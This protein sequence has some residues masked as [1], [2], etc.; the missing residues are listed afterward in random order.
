MTGYILRPDLRTCKALGC[1]PTLLFANRFDIRQVSLQMSSINSRYTAILKGLHNAIALDYHYKKGLIFWSDMALDVIKQ[2]CI[3]G[4]KKED[5][6]KWGLESPGGI[7]LDWIHDLIFWTDSGTRRVEVATLDGTKRAIL[8]ANDLDKPRAIVVHP[9]HALVFWT[10]WGPRPKIERIEMD[11]SNR[12]SIITESVFWPNGLTLDFTSDRIYWADAK[13]NVIETALFDGNDRRKVISKGLPHPFALTIFEDAIYWT[14]WHTK[15]ISTANK[16]TGAGMRTIHANLHFPMDIH[17]FHAQRQPQYK[18]H[19]GENNGGCE[20]LCLP[21]KN[22]YTCLCQMGQKLNSDKKTCQQPEKLLV[23]VR[24]KDLRIKQLDSDAAHHHEIV[25]P[26]D[27]IKSAVAIAWESKTDMI[28]WTDVEKDTINRAHWNGSNHQVVI[29]TNAISP[30]GLAYDWYTDKL[31]WTDDGTAKIEV[32]NSDGTL[33]GILIWED[34]DRPRD[35]VVD[36][37]NGYMYWSDWGEKPKIERAAMDGTMRSVLI[38]HNLTWPN[39]LAIDYDTNRLYWSDGGTSSIEYSNLDGS[40][41][42]ILLEGSSLPHPF[43]LDV[44]G[45]NVYWTDWETLKIERA[46]KFTGQNRKVISTGITDLMDVRAFHRNRKY[47]TTSCHINNGGCSDLCLLKPKGHSCAC[48]IGIALMKDGRTCPKGPINS[49]IIAHRVDIRQ[50]SL[51]VPYIV[52][53]V[54][55]FPPLKNVM[56]VDVDRKTGEVYWTDTSADVIQKN[57][58][59]GKTPRTII[60]HELQMADGITIDSTGRKMY[61]TDGGR[62]SIEVAELDGTNRKVLIWSDLDTPRAIALHY[63]HGLMF[64]SD[65]GTKAKIEVAQMDGSHR[66]ALITTN[67]AWPNGLAIDRPSERLYWND[68]KLKTIE[69]S[70]LNGNDRR[71]IIVGVPHP[72]GLVVVGNH[73]YWTDWQTQGLHRAEKHNGSDRTVIREKLEGLMDI[74][75]VQSD[76]IAENACGNN[77]GGCSHLCLRNSKGYSC[78]CPTG[79]NFKSGSDK[80]CEHQPLNYLMFT[81]RS[82][83]VRISLDTKELFEVTLPIKKLQ[84]VID[85]DFHWKKQ[86]IFISDIDLGGIE[87]INMKNFSDRRDI[88]SDNSTIPN[89]IAVD[90]ISNLIYWTDGAKKVIELCKIDGTMRHVV[91]KDNLQEPRSIATFPRRGYLFWTDWGAQPKIERSFLDGSGRRVLFNQDL[92]FP[93]GI[94]IDY[95]GKRLYW[96]DA[97][98]DR[99]ETSDLHGKNRIKLVHSSNEPTTH[100]FAMAQYENYIYWSDWFQKTIVRADKSSGT[101]T[102]VIKANLDGAM[103]IRVVSESRQKGWN[104]CL[105]NNGG[106]THLCLFRQTDYICQCPDEPNGRVCKLGKLPETKLKIN[107]IIFSV[108]FLRPGAFGV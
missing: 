37:V 59:D 43:G 99:V 83:I 60:R 44:F 49:L 94:T 42:K 36:P 25:V 95:K 106:C 28:Y 54:L 26:I 12:R 19:C 39:G 86:L 107:L 50:I 27:G 71:V 52:D 87:S 16:Q 97:K 51:D 15:A 32:A 34:L 61:W 23:F 88:I 64:W 2:A 31:Y 89:G 33:R 6:I 93:N 7:A 47:S 78:Q 104:P 20:H 101:K 1:S 4:D 105:V 40:N 57:T 91:I 53:Y 56:S 45:D 62:N 58:P 70:D 55:P 108:F 24:K 81:T 66:R 100:P 65:W 96:A 79:I 35:I 102:S 84:H 3:N 85:V 38:A 11:G 68:G 30:A 14:D 10:D 75:S 82:N 92:G 9:G 98:W 22:S 76:N 21:N 73:M 67:L 46:N 48:P 90:W 103:G 5:V 69:S 13:H 72:Y 17:S 80:I 29:K 63:H 41:R 8:V 74:R 18:N 77:N